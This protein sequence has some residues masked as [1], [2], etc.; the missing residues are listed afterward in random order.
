M[1]SQT[2]HISNLEKQLQ[3]PPPSGEESKEN[4]VAE[5]G[6][7]IELLKQ[8]RENNKQVHE[9]LLMQVIYDFVSL[10]VA[11]LT[12]FSCMKL[13]SNEMHL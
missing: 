3:K 2:E 5:L 6:E 8:E 13:L 11:W 9:Q 10:S 12:W 4:L 1:S 7:E